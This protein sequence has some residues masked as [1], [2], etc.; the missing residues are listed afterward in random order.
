MRHTAAEKYAIIRLVEGSDLPVRHTLRELQVHRSTF[1]A[2]RSAATPRTARLRRPR[3]RAARRC[4]QW[5]HCGNFS[6]FRKHLVALPLREQ[7]NQSACPEHGNPE[8]SRNAVAF[9]TSIVALRTASL[10][11]A[12]GRHECEPAQDAR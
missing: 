6:S 1:Y 10:R 5:S 7:P 9:R 11:E 12:I 4:P 8:P 2:G 3:R